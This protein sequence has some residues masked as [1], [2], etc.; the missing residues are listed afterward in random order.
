MTTALPRPCPVCGAEGG[1]ATAVDPELVW[2][3]LE[4][5]FGVTV[6]SDER[7]RHAPG[8]AW[9]LV[10]CPDCGLQHFADAPQGSAKFYGLLMSGELYYE[11][12]R[13]EFQA[14]RAVLAPRARVVDIG[15]G[16]GA[17]LRGLP[18]TTTRTGLDHNQAAVEQ[19]RRTCP[20]I[21]A[22]TQDASEHADEVGGRY[23]AVTAFQVLEHVEDPRALLRAAKRLCATSGRIYVSV[24]HADRSGKGPFE[25]LDHPPHHLSRWRAEQMARAAE[26]EGLAVLR[27]WYEPPDESVRMMA[28]TGVARRTLSPLPSSAR[29]Q[30]T[31]AFRRVADQVL[32]RR[33]MI[34]SGWYERRGWTGHTML[35]E[36][37]PSG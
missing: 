31:R 32:L 2:S 36:L 24:P 28:L 11:D 16:T 7:T 13:W 25:V 8:G 1:S 37:A 17:F 23:D 27:T 18:A 3:A 26:Q 9:T 33:R 35:V 30:L 14:V 4:G 20:A 21:D 10:T 5:Q 22:R 6:P 29:E 34:A 19:L 15:C 12:D